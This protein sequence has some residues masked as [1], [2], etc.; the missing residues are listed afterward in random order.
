MR[1]QKHALY[2]SA[3]IDRR[4]FIQSVA[5]AAAVT[6]EAEA[7]TGTPI[8]EF[9]RDGVDWKVYEDLSTRDGALTFVPVRGTQRA[10]SAWRSRI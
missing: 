8:A 2:H 6:V 1:A 4:E 9:T 7:Q 5:L 10:V 3:V